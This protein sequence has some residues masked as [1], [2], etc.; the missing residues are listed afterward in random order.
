MSVTTGSGCT[1]TATSN[2]AW[3]TITS[4][5]SGSGNGSVGYSM[6]ANSEASPRT[7]TLT[8]AGQTFTVT[9]AGRPAG[10]SIF[11]ASQFF[12][13]NVGFTGTV[14]VTAGSGGCTWTANSND[15]WI[16]ITSGF[17]GTGDGAVGYSVAALRRRQRQFAHWDAEHRRTDV[18]RPAV[19]WFHRAAK[20][21]SRPSTQF[22]RRASPLLR[23]AA[24]EPSLLRPGPTA[25]GWPR[26]I[27]AS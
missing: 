17:S 19:G 11:P 25:L 24:P 5:A 2:D 20:L 3:I 23:A 12:F 18:R 10:C 15:R 8:I 14:A 1:W 13:G 4:G 6:A 26:A 16:T 9:Q 27:P 21:Q 7:G 22:L